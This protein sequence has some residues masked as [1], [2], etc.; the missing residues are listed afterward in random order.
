[1]KIYTYCTPGPYEAEA[2]ELVASAHKLDLEAEVIRKPDAGSWMANTRLK[3]EVCR[4]LLLLNDPFLIVDADARIESRYVKFWDTDVVDF[5]A[6]WFRGC[7]L[8]SGT[9]Y[10]MPNNLT[11][12]LVDRWV[13]RNEAH[14]AYLEQKNLEDVVLHVAGLSIRNLRPEYCWI[15]SDDN[16][17]PDGKTP[18]LSA[19]EYPDAST[20]IIRHT[21]ASRRYRRL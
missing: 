17:G 16:K 19:R 9:L 6:H 18:D 4:D 20:P 1:M 3:A 13:N 7:E 11:S 2:R 14:P 5:A 21:Q 15:Q 10:F 8:L 12:E